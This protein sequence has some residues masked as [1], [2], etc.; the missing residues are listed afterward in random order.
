M[1]KQAV[2]KL[3]FV[4]RYD[5]CRH[6]TQRMCDKPILEK[7]ETLESVAACYKNQ[8]MCNKPVGNYPHALKFAPDS[9]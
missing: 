8:E 9:C 4:I 6:N 5:L 1:C 2:T 3:P 7:D